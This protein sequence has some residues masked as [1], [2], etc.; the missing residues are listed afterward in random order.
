MTVDRLWGTW[1]FCAA[2]GLGLTATAMATDSEWIGSTGRPPGDGV[3]FDDPFNWSPAGVPGI[4]DSAIFQEIGGNIAL[5]GGLVTLDRLQA[6]GGDRLFVTFDLAGGLLRLLAPDTSG[7]DRS[8]TVGTDGD[9]LAFVTLGNGTVQADSTGVATAAG[10]LGNL[11]IDADTLLSSLGGFDIGEFGD[12]EVD[13]AGQV[14]AGPTSV[15]VFSGS[16]GAVN[17]VGDLSLWITLGDLRIGDAGIGILSAVD[18]AVVVSAGDLAAALLNGSDAMLEVDGIGSALQ[19]DGNAWLG[20]NADEAGGT[21]DLVVTDLGQF[22]VGGEIRLWSGATGAVDNGFLK[23]SALTVEGGSLAITGTGVASVSETGTATA[24]GLTVAVGGSAG[25]AEVS[26]GGTLATTDAT[27][28]GTI[29][30][31]ALLQL[32]DQGSNLDAS[33]DVIAGWEPEPWGQAFGGALISITDGASMAAGGTVTLRQL[34]LLH[35]DNGTVAAGGLDATGD[36]TVELVLRTPDSPSIDVAEFASLDGGLFVGVPGETPAVGTFYEV[37][38]APSIDGSF[39]VAVAPL[40]PGFRYVE[41][42]VEFGKGNNVSFARISELPAKVVLEPPVPSELPAAPNALAV[43][44]F[45]N[46][47]SP[48]AVVT[49]PTSFNDGTG[50][51]NGVVAI[52]INDASEPGSPPTFKIAATAPTGVEPTAVGVGDVNGD[53]RPD[54][55][56]SNSGDGTVGVY[57]NQLGA[58]GAGLQPG[59][60]I[61]VGGRPRGLA[62]AD[63]NGDGVVDVVVANE[64][65]NTIDVLI[66]DGRGTFEV[67]ESLGA[68]EGPT[69]VNPGDLDNDKDLDIIAVNTG[70]ATLAG[71]EPKPSVSVYLN[72]ASQKQSGFG[73]R[74]PYEVGQGASAVAT[75]D[76]NGDG[77][78]DSVSANTISGTISVLVGDVG[79]TF[80]P[81]VELPAA[82]FPTA[83]ALGDFDSDPG[84]DPDVAFLVLDEDNQPRLNIYRNDS[85]N[86]QVI[87]TL[88][89]DAQETLG[90]PSAIASGNADLEGPVDLVSAGGG[91]DGEAGGFVSV[92]VSAPENCPADLNGD[93]IVD[94]ADLGI[95]LTDFGMMGDDLP[96]DINGDNVVNIGDVNA[97]F[98][99][100]GGCPD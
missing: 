56:V 54:V 6:A 88:I 94:G 44:L 99:A 13:S 93:G 84:K 73:P 16:S 89:T 33:G 66:N 5:P 42:G 15:G 53:G 38:R 87:L 47:A 74:I 71:E 68:G 91:A 50:S 41:V 37:V 1:R 28:G 43:G 27:I 25:T 10:A 22:E 51:P 31:M 17:C 77:L 95:V 86:G 76:L 58:D 55:I 2:I 36:G 39:A 65:K 49:V 60:V 21:A 30:A 67:A 7:I 63:F 57:L 96:A 72:L 20:G 4:G 78:P 29:G 75:G 18:G 64:T 90:L 24:P 69:G 62:V 85:I 98:E 9:E 46:D 40:L 12:G 3:S 23:S 100:W 82:G 79:G 70:F 83:I 14:L 34:G 11:Q 35:L 92:F 97:L 59:Q 19:V 45:D 26:S 80:H 81:A 52:L 32:A 61:A 48:D 8:F